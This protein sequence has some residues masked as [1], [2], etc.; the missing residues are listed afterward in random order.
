MYVVGI[1][2]NT[3]FHLLLSQFSEVFIEDITLFIFGSSLFCFFFLSLM[4]NISLILLMFASKCIIIH[5]KL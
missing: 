1:S 3:V 5:V 4:S 2:S